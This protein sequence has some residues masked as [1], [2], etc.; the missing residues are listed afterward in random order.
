VVRVKREPQ[1]VVFCSPY[2]APFSATAGF[3][4]AKHEIARKSWHSRAQ[5]LLWAAN[6]G[7]RVAI[8][9]TSATHGVTRPRSSQN[10]LRS[11]LR[12]YAY[13]R[14]ATRRRIDAIVVDSC[15]SCGEQ[16]PQLSRE[17]AARFRCMSQFPVFLR[18]LVRKENAAADAAHF[19]A[20]RFS[21]RKERP[22]DTVY[23]D[24]HAK[25]CLSSS[26]LP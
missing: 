2:A 7:L 22:W 6:P 26:R 1:Y 13:R 21:E 23:G 12:A 20:P 10:H 24:S 4:C 5:R 3:R 18:T 11:L 8:I 19:P 16:G 25:E 14:R 9:L 15:G 17:S